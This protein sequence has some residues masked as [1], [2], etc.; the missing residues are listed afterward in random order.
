MRELKCTEYY[1]EYKLSWVT[2]EVVSFFHQPDILQYLF[3]AI[4]YNM[5]LYGSLN[6]IQQHAHVFSSMLR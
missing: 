2:K 1:I 5:Q 3:R 6:G 4:I